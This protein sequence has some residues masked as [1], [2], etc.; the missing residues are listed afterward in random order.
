[1][2]RLLGLPSPHVSVSGGKEG[3]RGKGEG[4]EGRNGAEKRGGREG[5]KK[6][7]RRQDV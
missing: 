3:M 4:R 7:R 1:M 2:S 6:R 5:G